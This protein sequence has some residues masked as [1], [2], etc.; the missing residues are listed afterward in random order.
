MKLSW[1]EIKC[2]YKSV[3]PEQNLNQQ[4]N[5]TKNKINNYNKITGAKNYGSGGW[6]GDG[7]WVKNE[8]MKRGK[9]K[10]WKNCITMR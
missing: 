8:K 9:E 10:R 2:K 7:R 1:C 5:W 3:K 4:K 6:L